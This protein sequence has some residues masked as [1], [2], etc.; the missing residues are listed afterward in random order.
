MGRRDSRRDV[1]INY[2]GSVEQSDGSYLNK[3]DTRR[4]FNEAGETH[5]EDGPAVIYDDGEVL[6]FLN[7]MYY[8]FN[9]WL[10]ETPMSSDEARMLLRLRY[11]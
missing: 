10:I 3:H 2:R 9:A 6:W 5:R 8:S 1:D 4:W 7:G 11:A